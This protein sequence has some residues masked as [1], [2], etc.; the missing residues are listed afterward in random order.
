MARAAAT[1]LCLLVSLA[2]P[3]ATPAA[4]LIADLQPDEG[5]GV[6]L[7]EISDLLS[8]GD[9][10]LFVPEE[11]SSGSE[12]WITDGTSAGTELLRDLCSGSC[13]S[14]PK[15]LGVIG[16]TGIFL[17]GSDAIDELARG[18]ILRS[19]G[20]RQGTRVVTSEGPVECDSVES[21]ALEGAILFSGDA[22]PWGC[23]LWRTDG[24]AAGTHLVADLA[25]GYDSSP[26]FLTAAGGRVFFAAW[27][28]DAGNGLWRSDGTAAGTVL[29]RS[30]PELVAGLL[31]TGPDILFLHWG[32]SSS[33]LWRSDGT[34]AGTVRIA[35][36]DDPHAFD[37]SHGGRL[38]AVQLGNRVLFRAADGLN[39]QRLWT[40]SGPAW[41]AAPLAGCPGGCPRLLDPSPLVA[42]GS[43][44]LFSAYS[45]A[46]STDLWS[47]DGTGP[48]TRKV[49][50]L[51]QSSCALWPRKILPLLG[52][53]FFLA[54]SDSDFALWRTDGTAAGTVRVAAQRR[55]PFHRDLRAAQIGNRFV[56]VGNSRELGPELWVSDGT[57]DGTGPLTVFGVTFSSNPAG[58]VALGDRV[59]FLTSEGFARHLWLSG[60]TAA[61][62]VEVTE[63]IPFE[64]GAP[65]GAPAAGVLFFL[66]RVGPDGNTQL[67]RTDGTTAGTLQL[68]PT[69]LELVADP[70]AFGGKAV[71]PASSGGGHSLWESD[72]TPAG[73]RK[74]LDL[75][76]G[77]SDIRYLSALGPE[78]WFAADVGGPGR[79]FRS[80]GTAAGTRQVTTAEH[81]LN[82]ASRPRLAR[83][84]AQVFFA[85]TGSG[86]W[87][88]DGTA[89]GTAQVLKLPSSGGPFLDLAE[90]QGSLYLIGNDGLWKSDGTA[91]GT[92]LLQAFAP[93]FGMPTF[94]RLNDHLY[95]SAADGEH[96]RE[97]WR[98][99]G[100]AEGTVL[101]RDIA[102]GEASS[103]PE[104]L[105]AAEGRLFFT[106]GTDEHGRELWETDGT[107][108]GTRLVQDIA[109]G[110]LS[111]APAELTAA[112]GKLFFSADDLLSGRE[113]W[114]HLLSGGGCQADAETLCLG[115]GRF[116]VE[117]SWRDFQGNEGRGTAVALTGDTGYFWFFDPANVEVILKVL[118]GQGLNG[119]HWVFYGA[120]STVEY[121]LTVTDT[122]TGAARRY[123]NPPG[124]LGSVAD[125]RAFGPLGAHA[126]ELTL[127]HEPI[128]LTGKA[129]VAT[130][131]PAA[132]R[133]CLQGGRFAVEARWTDFQGNQGVGKAV[134]LTGDTGWFWFFDAANVEVVLKVLDGRPLNGKHWVFYGALSSVEYTL[135]VTDT[136][137]GKTRTYHNPAGRL[138]SGAD[139]GAF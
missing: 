87:R 8:L 94:T 127:E 67:W 6:S 46:G 98:T 55:D 74:L 34:A 54:G 111:S 125:T 90:L 59:A 49:A 47:T 136:E 113:P 51:C 108:A 68:T 106:A 4:E 43:R 41:Q 28:P 5:P 93:T 21:A 81:G 50:T 99:D 15:P 29:V 92:V 18:H 16:R 100:T 40:A 65:A 9:R 124:R 45:P 139:T 102:P 17:A 58:L 66:K 25:Q 132:T 31:A 97:L 26:R 36:F 22:T 57:T 42:L 119:H 61:S 85:L 114:V 126:P 89:A 23:E 37:P 11:P 131:E 60:G 2:L 109:P 116:R 105:E 120:L 56:F 130:C 64:L 82:L 1:F 83:L 20:T 35:A 95:F 13:S 104:D 73:T 107:E 129:T 63:T 103:N 75:P 118:D 12:L 77:L 79:L 53:G 86:L 48:G 3:S 88:T 137:T 112:G 38:E 44:I 91:A 121:T 80:D 117:A 78:I 39:G 133:L 7:M 96:G 138:A 24:T 69:G 62:T 122:V 30:F 134:T 33:E 14:Y 123:V 101:V 19:D 27:T 10:A 52:Q 135:T 72:G 70:V 71:A 76:A 32:E 128:V 110:A 84:G 115:G